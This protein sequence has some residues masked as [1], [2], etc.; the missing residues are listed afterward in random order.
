MKRRYGLALL[1]AITA[2]TVSPIAAHADTGNATNY[3]IKPAGQCSDKNTG[4]Q[5]KEA[6]CSLDVLSNKL[7]K[8]YQNGKAREDINI[9]YESGATYEKILG[10]NNA[11]KDKFS[12]AP[13]AGTRVTFTTNGDK[14]AIIKGNPKAQAAENKIG[15][16]IEPKQQNRGGTFTIENLEFRNLNDGILINGG[17]ATSD[18]Y[19]FNTP[20]NGVIAGKSAPIQD[21]IIQNNNFI[22]MGT[23]YAPGSIVQN[24]VKKELNYNGNGV[25]RFWNTYNL[26]IDNN[27]FTNFYQKSNGGLAHVLYGYYSNEANVINNTFKNTNSTVVHGRMGNNWKVENNKFENSTRSDISTW[28]RGLQYSPQFSKNYDRNAECRVNSPQASNNTKVSNKTNSTTKTT[29]NN[30]SNSLSSKSGLSSNS[31]GSTFVDRVIAFFRRLD[32]LHLF[33]NPSSG[34]S[35]SGSS[36]SGSSIIS[37]SGTTKDGLKE[38]IYAVPENPWCNS[39]NRVFEPSTV[40]YSSSSNGVNVSYSGASTNRLGSIAKHEIYIVD[41]HND[42]NKKPVLVATIKGK[43]GSTTITNK[44]LKELGYKDND[45]VSLNVVAVSS[46]GNKTSSTGNKFSFTIGEDFGTVKYNAVDV[47]R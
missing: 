23:K 44:K 26:T 16:I 41:N 40:T 28:Y 33:H 13:A 38:T 24:G 37:K 17:V 4:K 9:V 36:S 42:V 34:S 5:E 1:T 22:N 2:L 46:K 11:A 15:L 31:S 39:G 19:K 43:D 12:F 7:E 6:L 25:V 3:Y 30:S 21:A 20:R 29:K 18:T 45:E 10:K 8:E 27:N 35:S 14:K 47:K 32:F